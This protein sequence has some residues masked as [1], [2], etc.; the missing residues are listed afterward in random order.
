[1]A[2]KIAYLVKFSLQRYKKM[3]KYFLL[4]EKITKFVAW[5]VKNNMFPYH[6]V[7]FCNDMDAT[8]NDYFL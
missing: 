6:D 7:T 5:I 4:S 3:G 2:L 8:Y 1:M